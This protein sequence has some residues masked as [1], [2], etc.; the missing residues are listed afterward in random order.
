MKIER[1]T[2]A[3]KYCYESLDD[4][5]Y[6]IEGYKNKIKELEK[7]MKQEVEDYNKYK[8]TSLEVKFRDAV[9]YSRTKRKG[10]PR[11]LFPFINLRVK[12]EFDKLNDILSEVDICLDWTIAVKSEED[13][14]MI[15]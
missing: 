4:L 1:V 9:E 7:S 5:L 10:S 14:K 2:E 12:E 11:L 6:Q 8:E 3:A 13:S 15:D